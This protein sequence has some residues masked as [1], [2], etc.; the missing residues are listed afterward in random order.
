MLAKV[1]EKM[2]KKFKGICHR[3]KKDMSA[4]LIRNEGGKNK[5]EGGL[6]LLDPPT[7]N[8]LIVRETFIFLL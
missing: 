6:L 3:S 8:A 5:R 2:F 1:S 4:C 7:P